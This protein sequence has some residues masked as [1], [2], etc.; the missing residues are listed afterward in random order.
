MPHPLVPVAWMSCL[1]LIMQKMLGRL[2]RIAS[3]TTLAHRTV[4]LA[5]EVSSRFPERFGVGRGE[6][7]GG[8][9]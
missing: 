2:Q 8:K 1:R 7:E 9:R 5:S 6:H 3:S 4:S